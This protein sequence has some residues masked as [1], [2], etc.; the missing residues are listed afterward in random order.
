M[1]RATTH[2][3]TTNC[4]PRTSRHNQAR[5]VAADRVL[6][7]ATGQRGGEVRAVFTIRSHRRSPDAGTA[8]AARLREAVVEVQPVAGSDP[9]H[10]AV[11]GSLD[12]EAAIAGR[13][14]GTLPSWI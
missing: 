7:Q 1:H 8:G 4:A 5:I 13:C 14:S 6:R 10:Q 9:L 3:P 11:D 2:P 12:R